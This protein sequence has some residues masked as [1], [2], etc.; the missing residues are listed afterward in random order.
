M[1]KL[2]VLIALV[3]A[4]VFPAAA[5]AHAEFMAPTGWSCVPYYNVGTVA[6][7]AYQYW[8]YCQRDGKWWL[9]HIH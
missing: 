2:A 9:V 3:A 7:Y 8:L 6:P 5:K 4:L 1:K